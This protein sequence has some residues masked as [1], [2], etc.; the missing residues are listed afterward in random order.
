MTNGG[1]RLFKTQKV[2][3]QSIV[4]FGNRALIFQYLTNNLGAASDHLFFNQL[5]PFLVFQNWTSRAQV[6]RLRSK[7]MGPIRI[8]DPTCALQKLPFQAKMKKSAHRP[9]R[10]I[11]T[12]QW[13]CLVSCATSRFLTFFITGNRSERSNC[14][15]DRV[16]HVSSG[17]ERRPND[18]LL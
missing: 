14:S 3:R 16:E 9:I 18:G 17:R 11:R 7:C 15:F 2:Y 12:T 5:L 6:R 13:Y 1:Q 4:L 10:R 8:T